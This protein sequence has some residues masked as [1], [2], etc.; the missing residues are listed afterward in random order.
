MAL[1]IQEK[2]GLF[3]L[4]AAWLALLWMSQRRRHAGPAF[5]AAQT[6][7]GKLFPYSVLCLTAAGWFL[8]AGLMTVKTE[9]LLSAERMA[10][11]WGEKEDCI[12][13]GRVVKR[14]ASSGGGWRL[15]LE[16]CTIGDEMERT[17]VPEKVLCYLEPGEKSGL[18]MWV[19]VRG[20][21]AVFDGMRNPGEYDYRL[22][23]FSDGLAFQFFADESPVIRG[24]KKRLSEAILCVRNVLSERIDQAA[25]P[26]D[27]G[28]FKAALLGDRSG[29]SDEIYG[30]YQRNGIS[31][32]L[33][34][35]GLHMAVIGAG[36][37]G[38][39]KKGGL[40]FGLS[41]LGAGILLLCY[42][43][44]VGGSPSVW[45][46]V[47]MLILSFGAAFAGRTYDILSALCA[48]AFLLLASE[49]YLLTQAGFQ[50]SFLAVGGI[51]FLGQPMIRKFHAKGLFQALL[52][53]LSVQA[54]TAPALLWHSFTFP[55]Y[56]IFLN[57][58]VIPPMALVLYSGLLSMALSFVSLPLAVMALG[59][60]HGILWFYAALCRQAERLPGASIC[61]GRPESWQ[62][63]VYVLCIVFG[64]YLLLRPVE[65]GKKRTACGAGALLFAA[66]VLSLAPLPK[67]GLSVTFLDVGQGDGIF[68]ETAGGNLLVDCGSS[69][70][71]SVGEYSLA[72]F[73]KSRGVQQVDTAVITHGDLDHINGIRYL[74]THPE[75]GIFVA[76]LLMPKAGQGDEVYEEIEAEA[77]A[78]GTAVEYIER[79]SAVGNLGGGRRTAAVSCLYPFPDTICADRNSESLVLLLEYGRFRLLLTGDLETDGE[80]EILAVGGIGQVTV[81]KA[82]HHGS[83][84]STGEALLENVRPE[85]AVFS[86]GEGNRYGH[87]AK[88]VKERILAHGVRIFETAK[89]GAVTFWTDGE[90][91]RVCGF[92]GGGS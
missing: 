29:L 11:E 32:L 19:S 53:S 14:E 44:L 31:H 89:S 82:G 92:L 25:E 66:G 18:G 55:P 62:L 90:A 46:S 65:K 79:G 87:P 26:E 42:G 49:P 34:I 71:A 75:E 40:G 30:L 68:L 38:V 57:L 50:L 73:L 13:S 91:V 78:A 83:K 10:E 63:A 74:L 59:G 22:S 15:I 7:Q 85:F 86:Y 77:K 17:R 35:S 72:P 51:V 69:Q 41:G 81:L 60:G 24:E 37:Y 54:A 2:E 16:Q 45:R 64:R 47:F 80:N 33:A 9:R 28:I 88:E 52:I 8:G 61:T 43:Y 1:W 6:R 56:G 39:L 48:A 58:L 76:R 84:S 70:D 36:I 27:A 5:F 4:A 3:W 23:C 20:R 12:L 67:T 21:P